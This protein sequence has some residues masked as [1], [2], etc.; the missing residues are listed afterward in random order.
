M[1]EHPEQVLVEVVAA[2]QRGIEERRLGRPVERRHPEG[3]DQHGRGEH[4]EHGGRENAPDEDWQPRPGQPGRPHRQDRHDH[5]QA[6][7]R[8]R[9]ADEGEE[10]D[11]VVDSGVCLGRERRVARP[12]RREAAEENGRGQDHAGRHQQPER[13]RLDPREGHPPGPDHD[14]DEV[15]RERAEN[16][17]RHD[18]HHHRAVQADDRQVRA[19][20]EH[21]VVRGQEFGADQHRVQAADEEE[22]PDTPEVLDADDLVVGAEAEVARPAALLL[23]TE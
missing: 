21:L 8:H 20:R 10:E 1:A 22:Q 5:V 18:P 11:V 13:E 17:A 14:R 19:C 9:D 7:Q 15:V 23:L 4:H 12:A 6:E 16:P 2:A 3:R